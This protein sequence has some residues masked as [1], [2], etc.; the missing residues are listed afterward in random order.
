M[1]DSYFQRIHELRNDAAQQL[2]RTGKVQEKAAPVINSKKQ[3]CESVHNDQR[4]GLQN[5]QKGCEAI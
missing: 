3:G 5:A 4:D 2:R 1:G